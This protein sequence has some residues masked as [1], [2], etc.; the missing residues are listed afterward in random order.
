[1]ERSG[2]EQIIRWNVHSALSEIVPHQIFRG[3]DWLFPT[4]DVLLPTINRDLLTNQITEFSCLG[5]I[6]AFLNL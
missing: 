1:M 3:F 4:N 2:E 5:S 6:G